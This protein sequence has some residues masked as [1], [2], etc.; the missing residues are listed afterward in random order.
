MT[1]KIPLP[2][3]KKMLDDQGFDTFETNPYPLAYLLTFRTFGTWLH[4]DPRGSHGRFR[5]P[6]N[7]S[8]YI[9]PH[10]GLHT[11]MLDELK[12]SPV[13]LS[14]DQRLVVQSTIREVVRF[15]GYSLKAENVRTNHAH[16]VIGA[17]V[18]P[19]KIVNELKSYSTRR[20]REKGLAETGEKIWARGASTRYLWKPR[21]VDAAVDYVLYCQED[22]PFE[23]R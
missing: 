10:S 7:N 21:H 8:K 2:G 19:N 13:R 23:F 1:A 11:E 3:A 5:D 4:G 9:E 20:L 6:R 17:A 12:Q 18:N 14:R 22:I 16:L 15:R